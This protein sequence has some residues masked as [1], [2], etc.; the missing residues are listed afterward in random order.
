MNEDILKAL[1]I[2]DKGFLFNLYQSENI[3]KTKQV[4]YFANDSQINTLIKYLH[5]VANGK[6]P[7]TKHNFE[8]ITINKLRLIKRTLEKPSKFEDMLRYY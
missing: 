2:R 8:K 5:Y 1:L 7:I 6:I 3:L 4:I